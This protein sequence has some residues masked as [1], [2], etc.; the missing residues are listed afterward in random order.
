MNLKFSSDTQKKTVNLPAPLPPFSLT[1]FD[2]DLELTLKFINKPS[3][4]SLKMR[5][6]TMTGRWK[7]Y[8]RIAIRR[9]VK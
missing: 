4:F 1:N 9:S 5:S 6:Q 2:I 3:S 8:N 7:S